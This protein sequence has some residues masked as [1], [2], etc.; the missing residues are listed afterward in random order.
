ML[1]SSESGARVWKTKASRSPVAMPSLRKQ[2]GGVMD[3]LCPAVSRSDPHSTGFLAVESTPAFGKALPFAGRCRNEGLG[4][5]MRTV[6]LSSPPCKD[7]TTKRGA[8]VARTR[9][10]TFTPRR[11]AAAGGWREGPSLGA[12]RPVQ[13]SVAVPRPSPQAVV[14]SRR[15]P[16][17]ASRSNGGIQ[18]RALLRACKRRRVGLG[19]VVTAR[20]LRGPS[21]TGEGH[22]AVRSTVGAR[23]GS[24]SP[25]MRDARILARNGCSRVC[26]R[27]GSVVAEVVG[28]P[29]DPEKRPPASRVNIARRTVGRDGGLARSN[30]RHRESG[31]G[32]AAGEGMA[33]AGF[34][35][36]T[37]VTASRN[38]KRLTRVRGC[39]PAV[40]G[41][42]GRTE[43]LIFTEGRRKR[44][45][46]PGETHR[47]TARR[48][49]PGSDRGVRGTARSGAHGGRNAARQPEEARRSESGVVKRQVHRSPGPGCKP[50]GHGR[51]A[52]LEEMPVAHEARVLV[53][54]K[55]EAE[56]GRTHRAGAPGRA[57][58][59]TSGCTS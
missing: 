18:G 39:P 9:R 57:A 47:A 46:Q 58:R 6:G 28:R 2:G 16:Q 13:S 42:S 20:S 43:R 48:W 5:F 37:H 49:S 23:A 14:G 15:R 4:R 10:G 29:S 51:G 52:S 36:E 54:R 56:V 30:L 55:W 33:R 31:V 53:F 17:A 8:R 21:S 7:S 44:P 32:G 1:A 27:V 45:R 34:V 50:A 3:G 40:E 38:R 35:A 26:P 22:G 25:Q 19:G 11:P 59:Q 24:G 12:T 41:T